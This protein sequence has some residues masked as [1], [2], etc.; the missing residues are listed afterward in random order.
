MLKWLSLST[1]ALLKLGLWFSLYFTENR[2]MNWLNPN[3]LL[4]KE[5]AKHGI[6]AAVGQLAIT[7]ILAYSVGAQEFQKNPLLGIPFAMLVVGIILRL[8]VSVDIEERQKGEIAL[9][10]W[11]EAAFGCSALLAAAGIS[12]LV[13]LLYASHGFMNIATATALVCVCATAAGSVTSLAPVRW[14]SQGFLA[15][16][17]LSIGFFF[18][19]YDRNAHALATLSFIFWGY[20]AYFSN[21]TRNRVL[22]GH[23]SDAALNWERSRLRHFVDSLPTSISHLDANLRYAAVNTMHME[24]LGGI[25]SEVVGKSILP[26][27]PFY[28]DAQELA[29]NQHETELNKRVLLATA[30]GERWHAVKLRKLKASGEIICFAIDI[31]NE[32]LLEKAQ[33]DS[34]GRM[35]QSAK[36]ASLGE[37]AG[38]I[39]HEINNPLAIIVGKTDLLLDRLSRGPIA[40]DA[41]QKDLSKLK[42]TAFRISKIIRGLRSFARSGENDPFSGSNVA[43]LIEDSIELCR[44]RFRHNS[45]ELRI[46]LSAD[47]AIA[48]RPSQISQVVLNLLNNG[49]DAIQG[50]ADAWI[51]IR[52]EQR[53]DRAAI[54]VT[55]SGNGIPPEVA[56]RLME[57]FFTT[58]PVNE[59]TG[60]GLS[61]SKGLI[62][63]HGGTLTYD[64]TCEHTRFVVELPILKAEA[65]EVAA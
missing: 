44:E 53:G 41:L 27:D 40:P 33:R 15:L 2:D 12:L 51:E 24:T 63:D 45:V 38:G 30:S 29:L 5:T 43:P 1:L 10:P 50:S 35:I 7:S 25:E 62:E 37:M 6:S 48:C 22:A 60:L 32:M 34:Q 14:M 19:L 4:F 8:G 58:K 56:A 11:H 55:D 36:M 39:S 31:H 65:N 26:S 47:L 20:L 57:P 18:L 13:A 3:S 9:K 23:A 28:S 17:L 61:I 42:E 46:D 54:I 21:I 59:G 64:P 52:T 16:T 49:Y